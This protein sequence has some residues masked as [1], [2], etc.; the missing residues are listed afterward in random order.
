MTSCR[1]L[2]VLGVSA[3]VASPGESA[4]RQKSIAPYIEIGQVVTADLTNDDVLT[5]STLAAGVEASLQTRRTQAQVSYRYERRISYSKRVGDTDVHS[6][7]ARAAI[8]VAPGVRI[9]G[10]AIATRARSD[11]RGGAPVNLVGNVDNIAQVYSAY[12]GPNLTK[13]VGPVGIAASYQYGYTKTEAPGR[14]ALPAGSQPLDVF[15]SAQSH[16]VTAS[17]GVRPGRVLPVGVTVSGAYEND[18]ASQLDQRYESGVV[19]AE[20][21]LPVASTLAVTAG[22][23]YEKITVTQ[24]DPLRDAAGAPVV[25]ARGRFATDPATPPR[26]AYQ[27]DGLIY[28]GGI[29]WRPG[30]RTSLQARIGQRYGG[31]TYSGTLTYAASRAIGMQIVVYDSVDT[32]ARQLRQSLSG[33]PT[34]FVDQRDAFGQQFSGCTFGGA[35]SAT[36]GG[37]GGAAGG[38]LNGVFQ[39]ISTS[40]YRARG[41][42]GVVSAHCGAFNVGV[43]AGYASRRF[44][45]PVGSG[46]TVDGVT[47]Q[48]VYAQAFFAVPIDRVSGING[49]VFVNAYDSGIAAAP[50]I[51]STGATGL[52]YHSFGRIAAQASAGVYAFNQKGIDDQLSAQA[53]LGMRYHF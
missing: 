36:G 20:A 5:Y 13:T 33:L 8:G 43:G 27:T 2:W 42:D 6:G 26:I 37:A 45:T 41:V 48:S 40:A 47:D 17:A 51:F 9:E 22:A 7:L 3:L 50:S 29:I 24:K 49:N 4:E 16:V 25:D 32:F 18:T 53:Q 23:G 14:V 39:S 21:I 35:G 12:V 19:R 34:S 31:M 44:S 10:G 46:F 30:P 52:Y 38:C 15:D 11:I 28:D 1:R